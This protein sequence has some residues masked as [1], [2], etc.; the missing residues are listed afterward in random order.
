MDHLSSSERKIVRELQDIVNDA[1][2]QM[3]GPIRQEL[4]SGVKSEKQFDALRQKLSVFDDE[5]LT[6]EDYENA[7]IAANRCA[8]AGVA[9]SSIDVLI[10]AV[11]LNR[12]W[13][14]FTCDKSF[15]QFQRVL[16]FNLHSRN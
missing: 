15:V 4:L 9:T 5:E 3:I 11:A 7:A 6:T 1:R 13:M 12:Q 16:S 10:C 14:V 8:V 2:A